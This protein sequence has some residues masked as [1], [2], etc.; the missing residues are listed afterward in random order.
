MA[1]NLAYLTG[2]ESNGRLSGTGGLAMMKDR[3][4]RFASGRQD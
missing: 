3:V 4:Q 2:P 1:T